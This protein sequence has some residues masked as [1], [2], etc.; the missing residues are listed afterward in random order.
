MASEESKP[1]L[2]SEVDRVEYGGVSE[3]DENENGIKTEGEQI[4]SKEE[5]S[6]TS[7]SPWLVV[8]ASF[9]CI[10]VLDG[11]MYSFGSL[12]E[13]LMVDMKQPR[14]TVSIAGSLQVAASAFVG[15]VAASL[16]NKV[17]PRYVCMA[18]SVMATFGLV[19]ASFASN[20]V[21]IFLGQSLLTGVGFGFM[22]IPAIVAVAEKFE[23]HDRSGFAISLAVAGAGAGQVAMAPLVSMLVV[24]YGWRGSL[25]GLAVVSVACAAIGLVMR[26]K[27]GTR[28]GE[29]ERVVGEIEQSTTTNRRILSLVLGPKISAS[30]NVYVFLLV[31][32]ADCLAVMGLYIPYSYLGGVAEGQGIA[33]EQT[34]LLISCI[35]LGSVIG[36]LLA[37][38]ICDHPW[39]HP[40][41]LTRACLAIAA[42][43]PFILAWVDHFWMFAGLSLLFG[44]MTGQ[45]IATT[46]PL[47]VKLLGLPQLSQAFGLLTA[48]RGAAS[49]ASP[50]LA[51][52]V[53][54]LTGRASYALYISGGCIGLS[55][56]VFSFAVYMFN[57]RRRMI[58]MYE[59]I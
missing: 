17:G 34:A 11:T 20:L 38:W 1:L 41:S 56:G 54:D 19:I 47:L 30:E 15:P 48:V 52:L 5:R 25:R 58:V 23:G 27:R 31:V 59:K 32:I 57:K 4:P 12:L 3:K 26:A 33:P 40:V 36:R 18:G 8:L 22:Y 39:L 51:G 46:S 7:L 9:L 49:L 43:L 24:E 29:V 50:P 28:E 14:S 37:G 13:P 55:A 53:V 35:G 42:P 6:K 10:C 44:L 21:G 45:W 2:G 16:V